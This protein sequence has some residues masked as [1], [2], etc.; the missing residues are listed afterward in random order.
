MACNVKR[1]KKGG[2]VKVVL[3]RVSTSL[4]TREL[5]NENDSTNKR[6]DETTDRIIEGRTEIRQLNPKEEQGRIKGGREAIRA[7]LLVGTDE[8]TSGRDEQT[9]RVR[10]EELLEESA[11]ERGLWVEESTIV[12]EW[13]F[14]DK[15]EE[16]KIYKSDKEG[17]I[18]KVLYYNTLDDTTPSKAIMERIAL[19]NYMSPETSYTLIGYTKN[20]EQGFGFIMEQNFIDKGEDL[21]QEELNKWMKDELDLEPMD[22]FG[23]YYGNSSYLLDD[24]HLKNAIK[25]TDGQIYL[26]DTQFSLNEVG[27]GYGGERTYIEA[28]SV[29]EENNTTSK[30]LEQ[31]IQDMYLSG[32][33]E[34]NCAI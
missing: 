6:I 1:N 16:A 27:E 26:I 12:E 8:S 28:V 18:N 30:E 2:V 7:S 33:L 34:T 10:Q 11:K 19:H 4:Q 31:K 21:T 24:M 32:E 15:G 23:R 9:S 14:I 25:S 5:L 3:D 13:E 22:S 20:T 29:V 17:K